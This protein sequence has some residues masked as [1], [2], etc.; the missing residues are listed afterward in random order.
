MQSTDEIV[1]K[2]LKSAD[3]KTTC[4]DFASLVQTWLTKIQVYRRIH[5]STSPVTF[6]FCCFF[7]YFWL[8]VDDDDS[9]HLLYVDFFLRRIKA[10]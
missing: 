10:S 1:D 5:C 9:I 3:G 8:L 2:V 7:S 4:D 6:F